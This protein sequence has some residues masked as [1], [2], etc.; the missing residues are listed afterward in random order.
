A[1]LGEVDT[2]ER[3]HVASLFVS[4]PVVQRGVG[5]PI[6]DDASVELEATLARRLADPDDESLSPAAE[7]AEALSNFRLCDESTD[8]LTALLEHEQPQ[9]IAVV[10]SHLPADRA[11]HLIHALDPSV[12][13]TVLR[14]LADLNETHPDVIRE[15]ERG[16]AVKLSAQ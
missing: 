14:R 3:Q 8:S 16:L 15:I 6:S 13:A 9:V 10:V 5:R 7:E 1:G 2:A 12:Q 4:A 11:A